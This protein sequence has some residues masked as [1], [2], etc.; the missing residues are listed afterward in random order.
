MENRIPET[1][2]HKAFVIIWDETSTK[3]VA[4]MARDLSEALREWNRGDYDPNWVEDGYVEVSEVW[5]ES[6]M[7]DG[8]HTERL[9]AEFNPRTG[10]W[11]VFGD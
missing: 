11:E 9:L 6:P 2:E 7:E 5:A 4:V 3:K 8:A 10:E 1:G